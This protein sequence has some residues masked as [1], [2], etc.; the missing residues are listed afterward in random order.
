MAVVSLGGTGSGPI[1]TSTNF[2]AT[3]TPTSAPIAEWFA[4]P[5]SSADGNT[6]LAAGAQ[7]ANGTG[8][9]HL[10]LSKNSGATW[11]ALTNVPFANHLACSADGTKL[12]AAFGPQF[13]VG[14]IYTSTNSGATW[15]INP[16]PSM[17]WTALASS[18]DGAT[19]V[20]AGSDSIFVS[21]DSGA[22]W[23]TATAPYEN[24]TAV[25]CSADGN[26]LVAVANN[27][28]GSPIYTSQTTPAPSLAIAHSGTN[29]LLSWTIP[30]MNFTLQ[31]NSDL[32]TTNW[33]DVGTPP[34][35]NLTNLRN[36]VIASP[37]NGNNFYRLK[38]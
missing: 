32:T 36:Q 1:Y 25:A 4:V 33:T 12:A 26:Q 14:R 18:A 3:W 35:L 31:Q 5:A 8:G 27:S 19:L 11:T 29:A 2:G 28:S 13:G 16:T 21:K 37:T 15:R 17:S 23:T 24:W 20:A 7:T 38:Y 34:V 10:Y 6:L 9:S 30:S 22:T